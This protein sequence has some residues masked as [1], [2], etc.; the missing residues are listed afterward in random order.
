MKDALSEAGC[1]EGLGDRLGRAG[2]AGGDEREEGRLGVRSMAGEAVHH[3]G[4]D[5]AGAAALMRTRKA[6]GLQGGG[7]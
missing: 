1:E 2:A 4:Q 7:R 5:G 6:Q 3:G